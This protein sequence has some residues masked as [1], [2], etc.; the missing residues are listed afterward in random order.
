VIGTI[1]G[2]HRIVRA[3]G[4]GGMGAVYLAEHALLGR[5][6]AVKVILP[7]L[8]SRPEMV[9][10]FFNEAR[11]A[12]TIAAPGIVQIYDFGYHDDGSAFIVMELLEG[13]PLDKRLERL[14][15][16]PAVDA[17]RIARQIATTLA[18]AHA[19][20]IVHRDLKPENVF[21][22]RD[23]EVAGGE[24]V[25]LL[26]FG[27][28]KLTGDE[29]A[30]TSKTQTGAIMGTPLYMSP[31]QCRGAGEVDHRSDIYALGCM[32]YHLLVGR[33]PFVGV[34]LGEIL[35]MQL[36]ETA[37][38]PSVVLP[39]LGG[40]LDTLVMRC[41][42]KAPGERYADM[43]AVAAEIERRLGTPSM[44]TPPGGVDI[45][46]LSHRW[47]VATVMS[48]TPTTLG[49]AA[50]AAPATPPPK[51]PRWQQAAIIGVLALAATGAALFAMSASRAPADAAA[52][53]SEPATTPT[54]IDAGAPAPIDAPS[55]TIDAPFDASIDA[56]ID[57]SIDALHPPRVKPASENPR[58]VPPAPEPSG[59]TG[60]PCQM[61]EQGNVI[62]RHRCKE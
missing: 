46:S 54:T 9:T 28:A 29:H 24:R 2:G 31:E 26:D 61:D 57:A 12:T 14:G 1:I 33:P 3:L 5:R 52:P 4:Q 34:G 11:A 39:F 22:V 60:D 58:S 15:R 30:A 23:N 6:A 40:A 32:L 38:P 62:D 41:L 50:G 51:P 20:G 56:P 49:G 13:E 55:P 17:L 19:R 27:I 48:R 7:S 44:L 59:D 25:K 18:A 36:Y 16:L 37:T 21:L 45:A 8:S 53:A 10:R 43:N 35:A 42:A 47:Q